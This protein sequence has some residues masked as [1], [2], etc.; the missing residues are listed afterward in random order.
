M[1]GSYGPNT[2]RLMQ[3]RKTEHQKMLA[4]ELYDPTDRE[5]VAGRAHARDLCQ[6][7]N[8]TREEEQQ[9]RRKILQELFGVGGDTYGRSHHSSATTV[10][11]LSRVSGYSS[12]STVWYWMFAP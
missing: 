2:I 5:L 12:T 7:L 11:T 1:P 3:M 9:E 8:A 4:G 10:L 6:A